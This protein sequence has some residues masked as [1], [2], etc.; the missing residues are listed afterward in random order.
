MRVL[1][2]AGAGTSVELGV[3]SMMGLAMEFADYSS[4]W[5]VEPDLVRR[6]MKNNLDVEHL[7]EELDRICGADSSLKRIGHDIVDLERAGKVRAEVEWFVQ[8]AAERIAARDAQLIWGSVLQ[9][10]GSV[11]VTFVTTNY[12]RAIELAA[13]GEGICLDDGFGSFG[14]GETA[15][16]IGFQGNG[17]RPMLI[18]LHGSTDWY[19]DA[20]TGEPTKLRHPMA[21]FGGSRL[22]LFEGREFS[23][24]LVLPSRE[25]MLSKSPY[26]RLSQTFHNAADSCDFAVFVGSSLRD[27]PIREAARSIAARTSVFIVNPDGD[28]REI[29]GATAI[30]QY[31][32]TFLASTLPNALLKRDP[33][34]VLQQPIDSSAVTT[35][36]ILPALRDVLDTS[37]E[38]SR[39]C[40]AVEELDEMEATLFPSRLKQLLNDNDATVARY[41]IG[42][43][44]SSTSREELIEEA[45]RCPHTGDSAFQ[46]ELKL[47]RRMIQSEP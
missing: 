15:H 26:P 24:A 34:T 46:E 38:V 8:H 16:W 13:N 30:S 22:S 31:A 25:K 21:L 9:V 45:A 11:D 18:K 40:H 5:S 33:M 29:E 7:I 10:P 28:D 27:E 44:P 14:E 2:F 41:A 17:R 37:V 42:L 12:D 4:Q 6:I 32:S 35:G 39:R 36:G 43:I 23:S 3:P 19:A 20:Q 47:L 1:L